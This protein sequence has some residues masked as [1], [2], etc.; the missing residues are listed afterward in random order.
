VSTIFPGFIRDAGMFHDAGVKLPP[1]V[2]TKTPEQVADAVVKAIEHDRAEVDVAPLPMRLGAAFA[3]LAPEVAAMV[4]RR[5]GAD[6][7]SS[8]FE[9]GQ[10][11]KR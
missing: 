11:D 6:R 1:Y 10:R 4:Q 9:R 7:L 2:G 5:A 3:G 8:G